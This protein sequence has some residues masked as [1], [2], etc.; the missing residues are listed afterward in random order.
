VGDTV[1]VATSKDCA[2]VIALGDVEREI[3]RVSQAGAV[4]VMLIIDG[5]ERR[6]RI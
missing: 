2:R 1:N 4:V 5:S 6:R 3:K